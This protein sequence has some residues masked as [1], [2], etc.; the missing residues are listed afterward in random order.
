MTEKKTRKKAP[1]A[2]VPDTTEKPHIDFGVIYF[3]P[4]TCVTESEDD[5]G[6]MFGQ[7]YKP[8]LFDI[9]ADLIMSQT[10]ERCDANNHRSHTHV[11]LFDNNGSRGI[12]LR[13]GDRVKVQSKLNLNL[14]NDTKLVIRSSSDLAFQ[15]GTVVLGGNTVVD[16]N[17]TVFVVLVNES[18]EAVRILDGDVI[19][20]GEIVP[21]WSNDYN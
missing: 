1:V 6:V 15:R 5:L 7:A 9:C 17:G 11:R 2:V 12:M 13:P 18:K 21:T 19:A 4:A 20:S 8:A 14:Q 10:V 16:K 3:E